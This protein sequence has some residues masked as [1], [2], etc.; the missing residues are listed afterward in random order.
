M[1]T[2]SNLFVSA[3]QNE[4]KHS[5]TLLAK[6]KDV[7]WKVWKKL[8]SVIADTQ[9]SDE[10]LRSAADEAVSLSSESETRC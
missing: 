2:L 8:R 6:T 10:K 7:L 3:N 5:L 1:L 4:K 9:Y